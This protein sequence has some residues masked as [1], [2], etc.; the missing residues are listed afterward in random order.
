MVRPHFVV[1]L[2]FM[3]LIAACSSPHTKVETMPVQ[4]SHHS[5]LKRVREKGVLRVSILT[6]TSRFF[7]LPKVPNNFQ[8]E[9]VS[10]L[11]AELGVKPEFVLHHSDYYSGRKSDSADI[12]IH[13]IPVGEINSMGTAVIYPFF[14]KR[15][16]RRVDHFP[17]VGVADRLMHF[18]VYYQPDT[19]WNRSKEW[20]WIWNSPQNDLAKFAEQ[21]MKKY[22]KSA[23][24][25]LLRDKYSRK[26]AK[27]KVYRKLRSVGKLSEYKELIQQ[28][29][30]SSGIDW[31]LVASLAYQESK[32]NPDAVSPGGAMG[33][34][35]L[36][37]A[38]ARL[39]KVND[40]FDA[41][42]NL[43]GGIKL[44]MQLDREF[45]DIEDDE[46][47]MWFIVASYNCGAGHIQDARKLAKKYNR[48]PDI[49]DDNVAYFLKMKSEPEFYKDKVVRWG[50]YRGSHT[51]TFANAVMERYFQYKATYP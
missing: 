45:S 34:M 21:W 12:F 5:E 2:F 39:Y 43:Q 31:R 51:T 8:I 47:R 1:P 17:E 14:T 49:W 44:L 19:I 32:F 22:T 13:K 20:A 16:N 29:S 50:Y 4:H 40:P 23:S 28:L 6:D 30:E 24:Y 9:M 27:A 3:F 38:T 35:Q 11:A 18:N 46:Q 42:Q 7:T 41:R 37:R 33:M 15:K 36:V 48:D 25:M 10:A 26:A